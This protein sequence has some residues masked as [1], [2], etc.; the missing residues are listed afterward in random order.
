MTLTTKNA[1]IVLERL[2]FVTS[3]LDMLFDCSLQKNFRLFQNIFFSG[4][5]IERKKSIDSENE[6]INS[7]YQKLKL[8]YNLQTNKINYIEKELPPNA[9]IVFEK[10]RALRLF[11]NRNSVQ[12]EIKA[13][14]YA[15]I[16]TDDTKL[17]KHLFQTKTYTL[18]QREF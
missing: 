13:A 16:R 3:F 11:S 14:Q 5:N 15:L 10:P 1:N 6:D 2:D 8:N 7:K 4:Q 12:K 18:I 9:I 17:D